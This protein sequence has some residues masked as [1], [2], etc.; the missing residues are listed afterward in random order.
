MFLRLY[1]LEDKAFHGI[2]TFFNLTDADMAEIRRTPKKLNFFLDFYHQYR[3]EL[4]VFGIEE[5]RKL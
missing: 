3:A 1:V 4:G 5:R 2:Q